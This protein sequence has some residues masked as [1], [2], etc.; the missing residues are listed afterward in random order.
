MFLEPWHH[1]VRCAFMVL[2]NVSKA[3]NIWIMRI[4]VSHHYANRWQFP[5]NM[6]CLPT[7]SFNLFKMLVHYLYI[8]M[9]A[10]LFRVI[11]WV[12]RTCVRFISKIYYKFTSIWNL[13]ALSTGLY[14]VDHHSIY[15]STRG[16]SNEW[17]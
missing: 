8:L 9:R 17:F 16:G 5:W 1:V 3:L 12:V 2:L 10:I 15:L 7:S 14:P 13:I 11:K 4:V 6:N